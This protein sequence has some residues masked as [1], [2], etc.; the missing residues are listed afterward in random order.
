MKRIPALD[1]DA[2][3]SMNE[4]G[5]MCGVKST[6]IQKAISGSGWAHVAEPPC[7]PKRAS[8]S[9]L[10]ARIAGMLRDSLGR[11]VSS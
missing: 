10:Q 1:M 7:N 4:I 11:V 8:R 5:L 9:N 3:K 6:G 2:G